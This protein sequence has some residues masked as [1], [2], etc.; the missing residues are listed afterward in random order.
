MNYILEI[1]AFM[2]ERSP[3]DCKLWSNSGEICFV[4]CNSIEFIS[5]LHFIQLVYFLVILQL[6]PTHSL[7]FLYTN[8]GRMSATILVYIENIRS[9]SHVWLGGV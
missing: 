6:T 7:S 3:Q 2:C 1:H 8:F 4:K 5:F 9:I